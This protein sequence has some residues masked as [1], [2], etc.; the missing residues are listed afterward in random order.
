MEITMMIGNPGTTLS[1]ATP[2]AAV[3]G[4]GMGLRW[5]KEIA[6]SAGVPARLRPLANRSRAFGVVVVP[7]ATDMPTYKQ[8]KIHV[9]H[10]PLERS[11]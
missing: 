9:P 11:P 1:C 2:V 4:Q 7:A 5:G 6:L 3:A 8:P 10:P